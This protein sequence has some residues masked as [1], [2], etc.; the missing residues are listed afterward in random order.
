[1]SF[2]DEAKKKAEQEAKKAADATKKP[3][4]KARKNLKRLAKR[5]QRSKE[6]GKEGKRK[7]LTLCILPF[8]PSDATLIRVLLRKRFF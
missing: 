7:D 6:N 4:R 8:L 2:L 3:E 1:M 5:S